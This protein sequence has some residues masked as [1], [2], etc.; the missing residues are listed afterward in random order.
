MIDALVLGSVE[1]LFIT[2]R[3]SHVIVCPSTQ[4]ITFMYIRIHSLRIR[5]QT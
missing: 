3:M 2:L 1:A 5:P 4:T